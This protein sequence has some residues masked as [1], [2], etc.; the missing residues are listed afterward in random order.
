MPSSSAPCQPASS[1]QS[2]P[3]VKSKP[4]TCRRSA[5]PRGQAQ[6]TAQGSDRRRSEAERVERAGQE[7]RLGDRASSCAVC[8]RHNRQLADVLEILCFHLYTSSHPYD[9]Y[10]IH[11]PAPA[12]AAV[13]RVSKEGYSTF[14]LIGSGIHGRME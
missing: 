14:G 3:P 7:G 1:R 6:G 2:S 9:Y 5:R 12:P 11:P 13:R 8:N 4:P 10:S